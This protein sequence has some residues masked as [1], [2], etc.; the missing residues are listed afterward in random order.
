VHPQ[1]MSATGKLQTSYEL[2][3]RGTCK[4]GDYPR[5]AS[6]GAM[7]HVQSNSI[8]GC[9]LA[10]TTIAH[11][12]HTTVRNWSQY[13]PDS[14]EALHY[15]QERRFDSTY[16]ILS[17][18]P[19]TSAVGI[20]GSSNRTQAIEPEWLW[21]TRSDKQGR[22]G[23]KQ[24]TNNTPA[25]WQDTTSRVAPEVSSKTISQRQ[26]QDGLQKETE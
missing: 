14:K 19:G 15:S 18:T 17:V 4:P 23:Y 13:L 21:H 26:L 6:S 7:W 25:T 8:H 20:H 24:F 3:K 2:S 11:R 10:R 9:A 22:K 1:R 12:Y 5:S 16:H